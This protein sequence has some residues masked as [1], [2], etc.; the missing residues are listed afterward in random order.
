MTSTI[1]IARTVGILLLLHIA[2][3]LSTPFIL[4]HAPIG[5]RGFLL[6]AA[7]NALQLRTAVFLL[8]VGSAFAIGVAVVA[9]PLLRRYSSAMAFW[10]LALAVAAF[11]LQVVDNGRLLSMLSLSQEYARTGTPNSE[12]FQSL[13][14]VVGSARK[15]AHF[16]YLLVAVSWIFL[17][18]TLMFRFRLVPRALAAFGIIASLL[19]II[20][21]P[22]RVVMGYPPEMRVAMPLAPA[23]V[24]LALWLLVKGFDEQQLSP[25]GPSQCR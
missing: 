14:F 10:L 13:A 5:P 22:L 21:V 7:E 11:V 2:V 3:G 8:T 20:G 1:R 23:Y 18:F 4:L 6:D 24:T 12:L 25:G 16:M 17:L 9:L 19:Q 15:W